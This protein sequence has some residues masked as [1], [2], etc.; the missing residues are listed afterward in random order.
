MSCHCTIMRLWYRNCMPLPDVKRVGSS[1]QI[2][3]GRQ[4]AGKL[5]RVEQLHDGR[6]LLTPVVDVPESELWTLQEPDKSRIEAGLAW[7]ASTPAAETDLAA[8]LS[9]VDLE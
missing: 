9:Q 5:I 6:F 4:F 7:A 2:S 3:L 8:L 1:G